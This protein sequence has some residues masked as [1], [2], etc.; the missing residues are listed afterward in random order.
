MT[1]VNAMQ[2]K[3]L[4]KYKHMCE[5]SP[6][7]FDINIVQGLVS[8]LSSYENKVMTVIIFFRGHS[9]PHFSALLKIL[10]FM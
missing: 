1:P 9:P 6:L 3:D 7:L 10:I 8:A 2:I 5:K 4:E